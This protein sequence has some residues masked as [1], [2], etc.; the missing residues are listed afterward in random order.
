[1]ATVTLPAI[2][3][4]DQRWLVGGGA[5]V[6]GVVG[7]AWWH[8]GVASANAA[9]ADTSATDPT[10]TDATAEGVSDGTPWPFRPIGGSTIDPAAGGTAPTTNETWTQEALD[11]M[12]AAGWDRQL[13]ATAIGKF[14]ARKPLKVPDETELIQTVLALEGHPP[15]GSYSII[16]ATP[17]APDRPG[18]TVTPPSVPMHYVTQIHQFTVATNNTAAIKRFSDPVVT[19]DARVR[20]AGLATVQDP[21]N[22]RYAGYFFTHGGNWPPK[23]RVYL[24]VIKKK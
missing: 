18:G 13:V 11:K 8:R 23:S 5:L 19:T 2:G 7:F 12:E 4:V 10:A 17:T 24:H 3:Q 20:A 6:V 14:L 21:H 9:A 15:Q 22:A 1:M 16:P